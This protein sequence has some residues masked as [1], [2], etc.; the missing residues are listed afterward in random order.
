MAASSQGTT[1]SFSGTQYTV[2]RITVN[3]GGV[4]RQRVS[5]AHIG[6]DVEFEEPYV[7]VWQPE[8]DRTVEVDF[9]GQDAPP[10]NAMGTLQISGKVSLSAFAQVRST[11]VSASVGD[12]VRGTATFKLKT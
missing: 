12:L 8:F 1:F 11:T 2:T 9:L 10:V 3:R 7:E 6:S 4:D 5:V